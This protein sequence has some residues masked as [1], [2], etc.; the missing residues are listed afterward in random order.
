MTPT[1]SGIEALQPWALRAFERA[2]R[3]RPREQASREDLAYGCIE[4]LRWARVSS[5][6][7]CERPQLTK[8]EHLAQEAPAPPTETAAVRGERI[9][10]A[11]APLPTS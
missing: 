4:A 9:R 3:R 8:P 11:S 1:D 7:R 5:A 10:S 6:F 2:Y